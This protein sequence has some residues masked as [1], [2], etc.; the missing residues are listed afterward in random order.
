MENK[1]SYYKKIPLK[2]NNKKIKKEIYIY[3]KYK[4]IKEEQESNAVVEAQLQAKL[5]GKNL[6]FCSIQTTK[7]SILFYLK[8]L[9]YFG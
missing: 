7:V 5:P 2:K 3:N 9:F 1:S 6:I 4:Q 8:H